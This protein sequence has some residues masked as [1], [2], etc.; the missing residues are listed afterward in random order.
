M[1][2]LALIVFLVPIAFPNTASAQGFLLQSPVFTQF[3]VNTTVSVPDRG[4]VMMGGVG[5]AADGRKSFGFGPTPYGSSLGREISNHSIS[6][7]VYIT[8][9]SELDP[10]LREKNRAAIR[11]SRIDV[12]Q[13]KRDRES[14]AARAY[15][16]LADKAEKKGKTSLAKWYREKAREYARKTQVAG[17][18]NSP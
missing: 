16:K 10:F 8:D 7:H 2:R 18:P 15:Q 12:A 5:R 14:R 4:G 6:S 9:F 17:R 13:E 3:S 1:C 11:N